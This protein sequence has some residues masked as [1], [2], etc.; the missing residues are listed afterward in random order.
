MA[1]INI[2]LKKNLFVPKFYP[3]LLDYSSR[4]EVYMGSAG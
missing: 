3:M 2:T 4:W 1:E